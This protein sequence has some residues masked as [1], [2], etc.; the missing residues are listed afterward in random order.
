MDIS[1]PESLGDLL[2]NPERIKAAFQLLDLLSKMQ[3]EITPPTTRG[4]GSLVISEQNII[5]PIPLR[6]ARAVAD[7]T[8]G[9]TI[10]TQCRAKL[11]ELLQLMRATPQLPS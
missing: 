2:S 1:P 4:T 11:I 6:L 7:P 5:L 3:V 10:D 9:T 8:G